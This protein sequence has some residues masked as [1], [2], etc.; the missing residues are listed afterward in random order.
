MTLGH[1]APCHVFGDIVKRAPVN[2]SQAL[3]TEY[4]RAEAEFQARVNGCASE[5]AIAESVGRQMMN[6]MFA[7]LR[8]VAFNTDATT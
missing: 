2:I 7:I 6:N 8:T 1:F 3:N 4:A 5:R